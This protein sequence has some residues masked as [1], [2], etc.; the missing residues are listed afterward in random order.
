MHMDAE[1]FQAVLTSVARP[2]FVLPWETV[3]NLGMTEVSRRG[4]NKLFLSFVN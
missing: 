4:G 2:L 1:A 3:I